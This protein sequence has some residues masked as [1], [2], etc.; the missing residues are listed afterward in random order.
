M[1][2]T[3]AKPHEPQLAKRDWPLSSQELSAESFGVRMA[4]ISVVK[5]R[6]R[7]DTSALY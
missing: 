5:V 3:I 4:P 7:R 1:A 2:S 6:V